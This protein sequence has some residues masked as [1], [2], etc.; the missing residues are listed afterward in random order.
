M[1]VNRYLLQKKNMKWYVSGLEQV[2]DL[3]ERKVRAQVDVL[4]PFKSL[5]IFVSNG[6]PLYFSYIRY[7]GDIRG[8]YNE[9]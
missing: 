6:V 3:K 5:D 4:S 9:I 2:N 8:Y 1:Y 7:H